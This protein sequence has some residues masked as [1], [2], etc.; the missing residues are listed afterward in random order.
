MGN[1]IASGVF[2]LPASLA[3]FGGISFHRLF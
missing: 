2:L 3:R 1:M